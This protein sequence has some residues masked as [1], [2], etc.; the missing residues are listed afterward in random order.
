MGDKTQVATIA[1]GAKYSD[2]VSVTLG[3]MIANAP[4]VWIGQQFTQRI[5]LKWVHGIAALSFIVIGVATL[6]WA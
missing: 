1:L 6:I 5:S 2:I 4:A 3:M